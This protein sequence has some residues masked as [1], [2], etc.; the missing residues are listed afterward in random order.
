MLYFSEVC[1]TVG[2]SRG[3]GSGVSFQQY[4]SYL[5]Q[6]VQVQ[7]KSV[8]NL[9]EEMFC[10]SMPVNPTEECQVGVYTLLF[11]LCRHNRKKKY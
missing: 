5:P 10:S 6:P 4:L 1:V 3:D 8:Q 9:G 7:C 2:W 11:Y